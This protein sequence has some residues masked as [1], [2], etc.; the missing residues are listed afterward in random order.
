MALQLLAVVVVT[1]GLGA[2]GA[3]FL[4][5][6]APVAPAP[7]A[8]PAVVEPEVNHP[9]VNHIVLDDEFVI[10]AEPDTGLAAAE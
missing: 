4:A 10:R 3:H 9:E 2:I 7:A 6:A 5:P 1:G 8:A